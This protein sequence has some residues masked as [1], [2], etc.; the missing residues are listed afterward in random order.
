V[1]HRDL[2]SGAISIWLIWSFIGTKMSIMVIT[3]RLFWIIAVQVD[4]LYCSTCT[5]SMQRQKAKSNS[6]STGTRS[7]TSFNFYLSQYSEQTRF[8]SRN[9]RGKTLP[10]LASNCNYPFLSSIHLYSL[11]SFG[12]TPNV[13]VNCRVC[14]AYSPARSN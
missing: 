3:A 7:G 12:I 6:Q 5:R 4:S 2:E 10:L 13:K 9:V 14:L 8:K 1:K 11:A